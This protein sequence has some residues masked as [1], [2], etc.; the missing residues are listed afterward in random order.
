MTICL[1]ELAAAICSVSVVVRRYCLSQ[2]HERGWTDD[3]INNSVYSELNCQP[4]ERLNIF[5][6]CMEC[7]IHAV[8]HFTAETEQFIAAISN[9]EYRFAVEIMDS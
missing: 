5:N 8:D 4:D 6:L 9:S 1:L 3:N 2:W 7:P